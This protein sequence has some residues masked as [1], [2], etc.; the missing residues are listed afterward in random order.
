[1]EVL[2]ELHGVVCRLSLAIGS[3]DKDGAAV[4]RDL[5][6][7]LEIVLFRVAHERGKAELGLGLLCETDSVLLGGTGLRAVE[8]DDALLL[9]KVGR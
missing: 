5:V 4:V 9:C 2:E 8:N 3:N 7:I 1:M 6:K